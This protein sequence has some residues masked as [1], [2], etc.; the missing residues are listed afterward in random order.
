MPKT[1]TL[2]PL[3]VPVAIRLAQTPDAT[4]EQL[5][6]ALL[7][8]SSTAH[9]AVK[10]LERAQLVVPG[11]RRVNRLALREFLVHGLRYV[12]PGAPGAE[13]QGV[14]TAHAGPPLAARIVAVDPA[15]WP[16]SRGEVRGAAVTPLLARAAE[17]PKH[18]PDLYEALTLVDALR[19]GRARERELAS[20]ALEERLRPVVPA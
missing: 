8:S 17:L 20:A 19:L 5:G 14:P 13:V 12:F 15:V 11:S 1:L 16:S 3:D 7:I 4:F 6:H 18:C 9:E 2:R 10:R